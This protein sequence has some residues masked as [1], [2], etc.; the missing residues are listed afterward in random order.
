M[1]TTAR[2]TARVRE[3]RAHCA[4]WDRVDFS[5]GGDKL[6]TSGPIKRPVPKYTMVC[7][8]NTQLGGA[9]RHHGSAGP[10][11]GLAP[12]QVWGAE[13]GPKGESRK[14]LRKFRVGTLNV[15][16]LR[17]RVCEVVET[18]SRRKVDVCSVQETRY[19]GGNCRTIKG[20]DTRYKLYWSGNDR[21]TA[22]VGVFV[23]EEWIEKVFEVQRVSDRIILIKLIVGQLVLTILSVYAPQSG[24]SDEVK[25]QFFDQL[26][27][28]TAKIPSSELLFTCGDF[29]GHVGRAAT[30][31]GEVHGGMGF[32]RMEPDVEGERILEYALA[33]DLILGNTCFRKRDTHLITYKSGNAATQIDFILYPRRM[34]R[35][36]RD[37]KV[38]PG[39]E[40]ALQH[41][42]LICDSQI[43]IPKKA[44]RKFVPRIKVWKLKDPTMSA[45]FQDVFSS[46]LIASTKSENTE[47]IWTN[48]K[49]GLLQTTEEVCGKTRPHR[50]RRETWWWSKEVEKDVSAK[51]QAFKKWKKGKGKRETYEAAK[52]TAKHTVHQARQEAEKKVFDNVDPKSSEIYRIA[53]QMRRE[54][55]DVVGD[56]P[57]R[58]DAG[59]LTLNDE[60]KQKAWLEHFE[61][62]LNVEF[63]W[64]PAHL[65][66]E[67]PVEG[68]PIPITTDMVKKAIN[69]MKSGK[70]AGPSGIVV[71]MIR[72]A[73]DVGA[74]MVRDLAVSII[75]EGKVP[76]DW[77]RSFIV[78]LYKGKG[79]ALDRGNYRGLKLTE[80]VMK[81]L[82]RIVDGLIRHVVSID[83]SQFGFVPGR[84]T[85]DAIFVQLQEKYLA[86]NKRLYMAFVDLEKAFDRVPRKVIWWALRKL[87][88]EEWIVRLIQSMYANARS[89]IR[90][91]EGCSEEF[92]V[93]VGVHQGSVLSPLLFIIVLEAL[94]REF[95]SGVP[96]EDLYA[97]DLVII[98]ESLEECVT[99]LLAWKE[100]MEKKGLR[101]NAK[102][103]KVMICGSGLDILERSGKYPCAVCC[104]GVGNSSIMCS[105]C[106]NW[107]HKKCSGLKHI[108]QDPTYK[109]ARC[110]GVARPLDGRPQTEIQVGQD[111]LEVVASFCYLGDTL[112]AAGGCDL[113]TITRVKAAWRKFKE[114]LPI[115][116]SRHLSYQTRGRVY[117]TC[118]RSVMLYASETWPL[119]KPNLQRLQRNDRAMVRQIC[120]IKPQDIA[121]T[122]SCKLLEQLGLDDLDPILR[123]RRLRWYGHVERSSG[124]IKAACNIQVAGTRRPGRPRMTWKQMTERDRREWNLSAVDPQERDTWRSGVRTAMRAAS[125]L[126]GRGPTSVDSAPTP[127]R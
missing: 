57:V 75:R 122:R 82:E 68:P 103:T 124:A 76:S 88:V 65:S 1:R 56:K 12:Y 49:T 29:N 61:R 7:S 26:R 24:L 79:D 114:L 18:L 73:G 11:S 67:P 91:G 85:T 64:D 107:V 14:H 116:T 34:R 105:S 38:I 72:A 87:G 96:W 36:V 30:G 127:A 13:S 125:Q 108:R 69:K 45:R 17:G 22:G 119:S 59:E 54:N 25:D 97:D 8:T 86:V 44:K 43:D 2:R 117:N 83:D 121:T 84:G 55:T 99:R 33:Y 32:G 126:S 123:E 10:A 95:R 98:T 120:N 58:N 62:L 66:A 41:Q 81:V 109:C 89:C 39:N 115:L 94:S 53:S 113:A 80:Q 42:L 27:A 28:V 23:A 118:V 15:N 51:R 78:C 5:V 47:E 48:M 90:I 20:K 35:L 71:E 112:S 31:Y 6:W 4:I 46:H 9:S 92:Q 16:T 102:K 111:K 21:G 70:A 74:E 110:R 63:D 19:R 104:S 37:V 60:S 40:V 93:N 52:R 50:W 101:V 100:G 3:R 106:R 77:E